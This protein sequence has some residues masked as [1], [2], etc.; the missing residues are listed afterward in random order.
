MTGLTT[1]D[2]AREEASVSRYVFSLNS[3]PDDNVDSLILNFATI[4]L[5]DENCDD[6]SPVSWKVDRK[7][8]LVTAK[9]F[10]K[11]CED[12]GK[13]PGMRVCGAGCRGLSGYMVDDE[14]CCTPN[15]QIES[16]NTRKVVVADLQSNNLHFDGC[17]G[18]CQ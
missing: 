1:L 15:A 2:P 5:D 10:D 12:M 4:Q 8:R 7:A 13:L 3:M 6:V 9:A 18:C 17:G 14:G 11:L 16:T